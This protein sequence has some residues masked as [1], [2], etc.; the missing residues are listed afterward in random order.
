MSTKI[1]ATK[2]ARIFQVFLESLAFFR[3]A[4]IIVKED[5][6][7]QNPVIQYG[8]KFFKLLVARFSFCLILPSCCEVELEV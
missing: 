5:D 3:N 2:V 8:F 4:G 6:L 7:S 1:S